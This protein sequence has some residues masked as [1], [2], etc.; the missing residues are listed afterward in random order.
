MK[1][2]V[3]PEVELLALMS[4]DVIMVSDEE[5]LERDPIGQLSVGNL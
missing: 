2:Y 5:E 1:K 4:R 3:S